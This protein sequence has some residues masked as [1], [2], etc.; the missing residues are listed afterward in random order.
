M[1]SNP[2]IKQ[3]EILS[4]SILYSQSSE[5]DVLSALLYNDVIP[6]KSLFESHLIDIQQDLSKFYISLNSDFPCL[7]YMNGCLILDFPLSLMF[8][9]EFNGTFIMAYKKSTDL[10]DYSVNHNFSFLKNRTK[11]HL[12]LLLLHQILK[13]NQHPELAKFLIHFSDE[14]LS[15]IFSDRDFLDYIKIHCTQ[16]NLSM[17]DEKMLVF[18]VAYFGTPTLWSEKLIIPKERCFGKVSACCIS[19]SDI[20]FSLPRD[21]YSLIV[22]KHKNCLSPVFSTEVN[23]LSFMKRTS[24][25]SLVDELDVFELEQKNA[26]DYYAEKVSFVQNTFLNKEYRLDYYTK[27][28]AIL[29]MI[30]L[31]PSELSLEE[32]HLSAIFLLLHKDGVLKTNL[33]QSYYSESFMTTVWLNKWS[34]ILDGVQKEV[35][36]DIQLNPQNYQH[37]LLYLERLEQ[38][39]DSNTVSI[40]SQENL[41]DVCSILY[42]YKNVV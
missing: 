19:S 29:F 34:K 1:F 23:P 12:Q 11:K 35:L 32:R 16:D 25:T 42:I 7:L 2:F 4:L 14:E 5:S 37:L 28:K 39:L 6:S 18:P 22:P 15:E 20:L 31:S 40:H 30:F 27:I 21:G 41:H 13:E 36:E 38:P 9:E 10:I 3:S 26:F 24:T 33:R 17:D 8:S